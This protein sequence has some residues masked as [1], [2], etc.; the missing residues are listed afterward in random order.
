MSALGIGLA[1]PTAQVVGIGIAARHGI[2]SNGGG[3]A[4]TALG[5]MSTVVLDKTGTITGGRF[6]VAN[7]AVLLSIM[8][9][10]GFS[11][12]SITTMPASSAAQFRLILAILRA[13]EFT[14]THPVAVGLREWCD[15]TLK[16][17]S[18]TAPFIEVVSSNEIPGRGLT[19]RLKESG[20]G[21]EFEV[22][23][24]NERLMDDVK[25]ELSSRNR[26]RLSS[27]K[28]NGQSVVLLS[29][30]LVSGNC[31]LP[32]DQAGYK[33]IGLFGV[34]DPPR[35]EAPLF[36]SELCKLGVDVW[37]I[38]GDNEITAKAIAQSVGIEPSRVIAGAL[39]GDKQTW[40]GK[41]QGGE[42]I[43]RN[44]AA[45]GSAS[46]PIRPKVVAFVGDGINDAPALAQ[47]D[48]GF[49][50]GSGSSLALSTASFTILRSNLLSLLTIH[51]LAKSTHRKIL[52]NFAWACIY[53]IALIP[54][55]SGAFYGLGGRRVTLPP[56]WASAAMALSSVS[57]VTNSLILK[58]TYR[59]PPA[60]RK[61][62]NESIGSCA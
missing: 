61:W 12:E 18:E 31:D 60:V 45:A 51:N 47:A 13:A 37:M 40:V 57:V 1:A 53:N 8:D 44:G 23:I 26:D 54:L 5:S 32:I 33:V 42:D 30:K 17:S 49:A 41:L 22:A 55:A 6:T 46:N 21:T 39:P 19:A 14:S 25:S 29:I 50:M 48:I 52:S 35:P 27:W 3:D 9:S 16:G 62:R 24:G 34:H 7:H 2:I 10:K 11:E 38:S 15:M 58:Y 4:F 56:V 36:I 28:L 43:S 20:T 59:E